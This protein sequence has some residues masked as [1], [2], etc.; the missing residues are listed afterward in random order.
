M[1]VRAMAKKITPKGCY[2]LDT[3]HILNLIRPD[4]KEARDHPDN[5][6]RRDEYIDRVRRLAIFDGTDAYASEVAC[7]EALKAGVGMEEIRAVH[8][9]L[10]ANKVVFYFTTEAMNVDAAVMERR[11]EKLHEADSKI[12]AGAKHGGRDL[13]TCDEAL[14]AVAPAE[15][16]LAVNPAWTFGAQGS[17]YVE[18]E[19][20]CPGTQPGKVGGRPNASGHKRRRH[21]PRRRCPDPLDPRF[22][23]LPGRPAPDK[24]NRG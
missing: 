13:C 5:V 24:G 8:E 23:P 6:K 16:V 4:R 9:R 7:R 11:H 22:R 15:G 10:G 3:C 2:E 17:L 14:A 18:S 20:T 21:L 19:N 1:R 12:L